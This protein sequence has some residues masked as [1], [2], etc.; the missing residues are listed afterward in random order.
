MKILNRSVLLASVMFV[1][2]AAPAAAAPGDGYKVEQGFAVYIGVLP[3][4]MIQGHEVD[5]AETSMHGGVPGGRNAHH[6]TVAVFDARTGSRIENATV[7]ARVF[8][9]GLAGTTR[10]LNPMTIAG[11]ITYGNYFMFAD[12]PYR[13]RLTISLPEQSQPVN[14]EFSYEHPTR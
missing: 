4:A 14:M 12:G 8:P 7:R 3:A 6:L 11:T 2:L 9:L 1:I 13:I 5:H 10:P